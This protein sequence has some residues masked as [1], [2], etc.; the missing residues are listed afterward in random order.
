MGSARAAHLPNRTFVGR[1]DD[2]VALEA[3]LREA[4]IVTLLG[5]P[6][7]GKTHLA[8]HVARRA[9]EGDAY[10]GGVHWCA[11]TSVRDATSLVGAIREATARVPAP[12]S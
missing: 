6:G 10:P 1:A 7:V 8:A 2:V 12:A 3:R 4:R 9:A 11:L 5:P